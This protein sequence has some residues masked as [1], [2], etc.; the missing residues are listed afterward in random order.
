MGHS[1]GGEGKNNGRAWIP[2]LQ[3]AYSGL[4]VQSGDPDPPSEGCGCYV[5][6]G[7]AEWRF[8]SGTLD[9]GDVSKPFSILLAM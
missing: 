9:P 6:K 7:R 3:L 1:V 8:S 4:T 5:Q 2:S